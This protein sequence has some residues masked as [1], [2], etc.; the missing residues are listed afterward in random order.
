[1]RYNQL[2]ELF[3]DLFRNAKCKAG[4]MIPFR[5]V[6]FSLMDKLNPVEQDT[7]NH[8]IEDIFYEG[9]IKETPGDG[10]LQGF[11]L[12][13][14]GFDEIYDTPANSELEEVVMDFFRKANCNVGHVIKLAPLWIS[15][16]ND[17]NPKEY[18]KM[19]DIING[20]IDKEFIS[21]E[22]TPFEC[23]RLE[24]KGFEYIYSSSR[25]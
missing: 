23:L 10:G 3:W 14:K 2:K 21:F 18:D 19:V 8:V 11:V 6:R 7:L 16:Q 4:H 1:M 15:L 22:K 17:L 20:L 12:T 5:S 24:Q 25:L 13:E 9:L